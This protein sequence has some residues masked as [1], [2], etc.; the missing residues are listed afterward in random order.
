[1]PR[2]YRVIG[3]AAIS[4]IGLLLSYFGWWM[5]AVPLA[6]V[7]ALSLERLMQQYWQRQPV[8]D[9]SQASDVNKIFSSAFLPFRQELPQ[10]LKECSHSL[11]DV[12]SVQQDA[13]G[14]LS[15]AFSELNT[16]MHQQNE[17]IRRLTHEGNE[18]NDASY[19]QSMKKFAE[20]TSK[21]LDRFINTTIDMSASS[22]GLLEKV[23]RIS[24]TMPVVVKALKDID[25]ISSQTNLLALNAAIEAARAGEAGRGFAVVADEVRALSNRSAGFSDSIQQQLKDIHKKIDDLHKEVGTVA[26]QDVSYII[27]AKSGLDSALTQIIA[28]S[29]SDE[30]TTRSLGQVAEELEQV[31]HRTVR[32]L[33]FDDINRQ[34]LQFTIEA[35]D[36]LDAELQTIEVDKMDQAA[37]VLH[38]Q[39]ERLRSRRLKSHNPVSAINMSAGEAE[40]F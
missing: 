16:L 26:A 14:T 8:E 38:D 36:N 31:L 10:A 1:M 7:A 20:Q 12:C 6:A 19:G 2:L 4:A 17:L 40:L 27:E 39:A 24:K 15:Q 37:S 23:G 22:M 28:K 34:N 33:Q 18:A 3:I 11:K 9:V 32:G 5:V 35:L 25:Q 13:V 30:K 29:L 21:T